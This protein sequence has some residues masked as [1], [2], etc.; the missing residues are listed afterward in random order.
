MFYYTPYMLAPLLSAFVCGTLALLAFRRRYAPA[1]RRVFWV[2]FILAAW[3]FF[4]ALKTAAVPL[5]L[6][7]FFS[8][9]ATTFAAF[10]GVATLAL[11][12]EV[13]GF[14]AWLILRRIVLLSIIPFLAVILAWTSQS[15]SLFRYSF[16]I[17][18]SGGMRLL[19]FETGSAWLPYLFYVEALNG[20]A[21]AVFLIGLKRSHPRARPRYYLLIAGT[22]VPLLV[23]MLGVT[24]VPGFSLT[25]SVLWFTGSCYVLAIFRH[26]LLQAAPVAR[27]TLFDHL[28]EPILVFDTNREL[29]DCN[30][31]ARELL[32]RR[33]AG[34]GE[35]GD[36]LLTRFPVLRQ[37]LDAP[38]DDIVIDGL[39]GRRH[40]RVRSMPLTRGPLAVGTLVQLH[41]VSSIKRVEEELRRAREA[42]EA[43][44]RTKSAFLANTS[45][46]IRTP[47]NAIIGFN[48]LV[49][50]SELS[51]EQRTYLEIVK[52]SSETLLAIL[53]DILDSSKI[54]AGK[55]ELE[56][57]DF[58]IRRVV[59]AA[60]RSLSLT[61][62][63]KGI[64][65]M[66][67]VDPN[68][69]RFV[70]GDALRLKQVLINLAGNAVKFTPQG[71]VRLAIEAD[72]SRRAAAEGE[73]QVPILFQVIDTGIGI[74]EDQ[75]K[76]IFLS[77]TQAD[78]SITRKF[79]GTGLGLTISRELVRLM[80]G[81]LKVESSPGRGSRFFFS[82]DLKRG[83]ETPAQPRE[84]PGKGQIGSGPAL[85]VLVV[86][87]T[88]VTRTL[89]VRMLENLGHHV[90]LAKNGREA[91]HFLEKESFDLVFMDDRMPIMDGCE[92]VRAIRRETSA[93]LNRDLPIVA[94]TASVSISD[95]E[96]CLA[97]GMNG[98]VTKPLRSHQLAAVLEKFVGVRAAPRPH[99]DHAEA[100]ARIPAGEG[101]LRSAMRAEILDRYAGDAELV[102]ELLQVFRTEVP[103]VMRKI[104]E[105]LD[106]GDSSLL[107]LHAHSCKS[108]AG[109]VG[110]NSLASFAAAVEQAAKAGDLKTAGMHAAG[111]EREL[112][113]FLEG[114]SS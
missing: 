110:F 103:L 89:T 77:F 102:D 85:R 63:A 38:V 42:A 93:V 22:V 114:E 56:D 41:D 71:S 5:D 76:N 61:A 18:T 33:G 58:D 8:Q 84:V 86:E 35:L 106:A 75:Q 6:K 1:A 65:L 25:T 21:V 26:G 30:R 34:I 15:H 101:D 87:D 44:N 31:A 55:M 105:A 14:G 88:D 24:P 19:G 66:C 12:L 74:S 20:T 51:G 40:W 94:L 109:S 7:V 52:E 10:V 60:V 92:T 4:Y 28:D 3:S 9:I 32:S 43:A 111:L 99:R 47:M 112:K 11:A 82:L 96:R 108:A 37:A 91:L 113:I 104:R 72:A 73:I 53:D 98:F 36:V 23:E 90:E 16:H 57:A 54:E 100:A 67:E 68:V 95:R 79:G 59:D 27:E 62:E 83:Q 13:A 48:D 49:L 45:H 107:E 50:D 69:P 2:M 81:E 17:V 78:S 39:D 97:A 80:G 64:S 29:A 46:E 70:K